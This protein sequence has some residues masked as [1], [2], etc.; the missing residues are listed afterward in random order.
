LIDAETIVGL[1]MADSNSF[2]SQYPLWKPDLAVKG[3]FGLRELIATAL[4]D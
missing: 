1:M 3:V 4:N 2:V